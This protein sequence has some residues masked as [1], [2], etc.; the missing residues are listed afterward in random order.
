MNEAI[1]KY[2]I[3]PRELSRGRNLKIAA[4]IS[5]FVLTI[6]PA[7]ITFVLFV[8]FAVSPPASVT[9]LFL[10]VVFT[11]IGFIAGLIFSGIFAYRYSNWRD[12]TRERM[13]ADGIKAEEIEWFTREMR[14][15]EKKALKDIAARDLLLGDAYR[16][17]LA[18]RL[19][20]SRIIKSSKKEL[21]ATQ[22]RQQ[23]IKNLKT[24][25]SPD[26]IGQIQK[27]VE[28]LSNINN[29]ARQMLVEAESR[30]QMI[31]AAA[32]RG[33]GL[34]DSE[35]ALKKLSARSQSLPLALEEAKMAE[36]IL[37]ELESAERDEPAVDLK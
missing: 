16:E 20:A 11:I 15:A 31:E 4:W 26:F 17:T 14:S 10:G 18:S 27:D 5:P 24:K 32:S 33:G 28:K 19:T 34:A 21:L 23:R 7:V 36:S 9:I 6:L 35:L 3:T 22:R 1:S 8:L 2:D 30:L 13:A 29:D 37:A 25:S 12:E